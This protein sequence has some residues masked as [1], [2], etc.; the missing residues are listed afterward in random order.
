[1]R[2]LPMVYTHY[3]C[4]YFWVIYLIFFCR[5]FYSFVI[6]F[7]IFFELRNDINLLFL[8][9]HNNRSFL[10]T[11]K[12]DEHGISAKKKTTKTTR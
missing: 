2:M 11:K 6:F 4:Y 1:M 9:C 8:A 10:T 12:I 7:C 3:N 5:F